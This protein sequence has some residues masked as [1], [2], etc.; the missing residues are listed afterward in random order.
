MMARAA[1]D[2]HD[3]QQQQQ[4]HPPRPTAA[5]VRRPT[6]TAGERATPADPDLDPTDG[7]DGAAPAAGSAERDAL[8]AMIRAQD[9]ANAPDARSAVRNGLK[10]TLVIRQQPVH[11]RLCGTAGS[12]DRRP[13]DPPPVVQV[14]IESVD[15]QNAHFTS[16][17]YTHNPRL[18]VYAA[19]VP[20]PRDKAQKIRDGNSDEAEPVPM[21]AVGGKAAPTLTYGSVVS[22]LFRMPDVDGTSAAFAVFPDISVKN[23][24][25]L[26]F[27]FVLCEMVG[28]KVRRLASILSRPVTVW[29]PKK[30]PGL[31]PSTAWTRYVVHHGV[32]LRIRCMPTA[33]TTTTTDSRTTTADSTTPPS[34]TTPAPPSTGRRRGKRARDT[35]PDPDA[36]GDSRASPAPAGPARGSRLP[37]LHPHHVDPGAGLAAGYPGAYGYEVP[38]QPATP[39]LA[40]ASGGWG[41]DTMPPHSTAA[42]WDHGGTRAPE[43]STG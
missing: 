34:G 31:T 14:R 13:I 5:G 22:A 19:A 28:V 41:I 38:S 24:G 1:S 35:I 6:T 17:W 36:V 4:Q 25:K 26:R 10:Y 3:Q 15:G 39:L 23:E 43:S 40:D 18:F 29:T 2:H 27:R 42:G 9:A 7:I 33:R 21:A 16:D 8:A 30:F 11:A 37:P 32:K 20:M 12:L